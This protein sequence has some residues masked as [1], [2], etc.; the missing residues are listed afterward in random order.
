MDKSKYPTPKNLF[1]IDELGGWPTVNKEFFDPENGVMA[2]DQRRT[3]G[4]RLRSNATAAPAPAGMRFRVPRLSG[5]AL[6][7]GIAMAYLS[8]IVLIPLAAVVAKSFEDGFD[9]FWTAVTERAGGG[10]AEAD[11]D[12]LARSWPRS[13]PSPAR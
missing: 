4:S 9:T 5:A 2:V 12:R 11:A 7:G 10:G 8:L 1:T 13:T 6:G 3:R